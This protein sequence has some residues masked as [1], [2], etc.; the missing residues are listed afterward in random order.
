MLVCEPSVRFVV[1]PATRTP[2][3]TWFGLVPAFAEVARPAAE[4]IWDRASSNCTLDDLKP[5]VFTFAML[6]D[7]TSSMVC[8]ARR[9]EIPE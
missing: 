9:P 6:L 4:T 8:S 5:T 1:T 3:P 7:V 2:R